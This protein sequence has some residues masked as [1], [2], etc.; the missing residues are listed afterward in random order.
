MKRPPSELLRP[1]LGR[2][3]FDVL[4]RER[5]GRPISPRDS[6]RQVRGLSREPGELEDIGILVGEL[7]VAQQQDQ[8]TDRGDGSDSAIKGFLRERRR[9]GT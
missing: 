9:G 7:H 8:F 1:L 3:D 6:Q 4:R 2:G 5:L